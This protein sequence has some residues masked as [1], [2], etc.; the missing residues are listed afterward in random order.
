MDAR[1]LQLRDNTSKWLLWIGRTFSIQLDERS[2][3]RALG[4]RLKLKV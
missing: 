4:T 1:L 3:V 2:I